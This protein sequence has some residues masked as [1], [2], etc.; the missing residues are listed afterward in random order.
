MRLLEKLLGKKTANASGTK[1]PALASDNRL[2]G[3]GETANTPTVAVARIK[4]L[5][6]VATDRDLKA[7]DVQ[8]LG[9]TEVAVTLA[10]LY[11]LQN[12]ALSEPLRKASANIH[13]LYRDD[14][15]TSTVV[16]AET[17]RL[18][19][20]YQPCCIYVQMPI[21]NNSVTIGLLTVVGTDGGEQFITPTGV[22]LLP[23]V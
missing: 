19:G 6:L 4:A 14:S 17:V 7:L 15:A 5:C 13:F 16:T 3:N 20:I 8:S 11:L 18:M 23:K 21:L 22:G 2:K 1:A 12:P 10:Y 9:L